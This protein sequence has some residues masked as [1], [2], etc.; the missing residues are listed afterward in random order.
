MAECLTHSLEQRIQ[1]HTK[2]IVSLYRFQPNQQ[3]V[4]LSSPLQVESHHLRLPFGGGDSLIQFTCVVKLCC[5]L[6]V[7]RDKFYWC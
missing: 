2:R 4:P 1:S 6:M 5:K 7:R 3:L